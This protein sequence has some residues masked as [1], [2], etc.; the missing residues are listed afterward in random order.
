MNVTNSG[1]NPYTNEFVTNLSTR[2]NGTV[3]KNPTIL[4]PFL[5]CFATYNPSKFF[6]NQIFHQP[7][8][9]PRPLALANDFLMP[10]SNFCRQTYFQKQPGDSMFFRQQPA[11]SQY[12]KPNF[13]NQYQMNMGMR[14]V[15]AHSLIEHLAQTMVKPIHYTS[16][17][18][19]N[20]YLPFQSNQIYTTDQQALTLPPQY[21]NSKAITMPSVIP[22][23]PTLTTSQYIQPITIQD[24]I[25]SLLEQPNNP[26]LQQQA[27]P[28]LQALYNQYQ[29]TAINNH[30]QNSHSYK[31]IQVNNYQLADQTVQQQPTFTLQE[32]TALQPSAKSAFTTSTPKKTNTD[33]IFH[34]IQNEKTKSTNQPQSQQA[35]QISNPYFN[36]QNFSTNM[37]FDNNIH[38]NHRG[39]Y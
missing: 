13:N 19:P 37:P 25:A 21:A 17:P 23:Q 4:Q 32:K 14:T 34:P 35:L 7:Y 29:N 20:P 24:L 36:Q 6:D 30:D 16:L 26:I 22:Q 9:M 8:A 28:F 27:Q 11:F 31:P 18:M 3:G 39:Y 1:F 2:L 33:K 12:E 5:N 15:P 38:N 10:F